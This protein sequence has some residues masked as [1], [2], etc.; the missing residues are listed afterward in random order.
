MQEKVSSSFTTGCL[1]VRM[2][3]TFFEFSSGVN[4]AFAH[5]NQQST[6][7]MKKMLLCVELG[8][9]HFAKPA[10]VSKAIVWQS[11]FID[12]LSFRPIRASPIQERMK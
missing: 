10:A 9:V 1:C 5:K 6:I 2:L 12:G 4:M 11:Q 3:I 8:L 7:R